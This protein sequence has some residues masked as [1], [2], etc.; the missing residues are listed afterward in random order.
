MGTN[1]GKRETSATPPVPKEELEA[2]LTRHRLPV[3]RDHLNTLL[4]EPTKREMNLCEAL[5]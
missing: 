1:P 3:I 5:T 4:K 2:M